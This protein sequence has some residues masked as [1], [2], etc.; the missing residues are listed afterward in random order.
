M[1]QNFNNL[2]KEAKRAAGILGINCPEIIFDEA[3]EKA[4]YT[5]DFKTER[6]RIMLNPETDFNFQLS[7]VLRYLRM[8]WSDLKFLPPCQEDPLDFEAGYRIFF[9]KESV[10][11]IHSGDYRVDFRV[12]LY[13]YYLNGCVGMLGNGHDTRCAWVKNVRSG[14]FN[15]EFKYKDDLSGYTGKCNMYT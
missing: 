12:N 7:M 4:A 14:Q 10:T 8:I 1:E 3:V 2:L 5:R 6:F 13:I 11:H 15:V 9:R